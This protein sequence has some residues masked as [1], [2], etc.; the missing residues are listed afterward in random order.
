MARFPGLRRFDELLKIEFPN[1][2][3]I[4]I[5]EKKRNLEIICGI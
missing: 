3:I 5:K 4:E 2:Q 1:V